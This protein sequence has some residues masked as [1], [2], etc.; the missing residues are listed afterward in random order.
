MPLR[1]G[2]A[3]HDK[4]SGWLSRRLVDFAISGRRLPR[5]PLWASDLCA[6][7]VRGWKFVI[8]GGLLSAYGAGA[9]AKG[10]VFT[11]QHWHWPAWWWIF[12]LFLGIFVAQQLVVKDRRGGDKATG[13]QRFTETFLEGIATYRRGQLIAGDLEWRAV[14]TLPS[15]EA[16][17]L[18]GSEKQPPPIGLPPTSEALSPFAQEAEDQP[19][20]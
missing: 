12:P 1:A 2:G 8:G 20:Q 16:V 17:E 15:G 7:F 19:K 14:H 11:H 3:A 18:S 9:Q 13:S 6:V 10:I 4:N 5:V